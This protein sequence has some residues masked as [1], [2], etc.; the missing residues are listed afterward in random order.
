MT[1]SGYLPSAWGNRIEA[2]LFVI[3]HELRHMW[4]GNGK[5][6]SAEGMP[7]SFEP[8]RKSRHGMVYGSRG[9][10]SERDADAYAIQMLRRYRR[11]EFSEVPA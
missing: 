3:A 11:G 5:Q 6:A 10:F 2:L 7:P 4:Q 9:K 1:W 8:R